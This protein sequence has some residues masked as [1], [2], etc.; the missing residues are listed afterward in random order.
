MLLFLDF[1]LLAGMF[2][3]FPYARRFVPTKC[4]DLVSFI[5]QNLYAG[6]DVIVDVRYWLINNWWKRKEYNVLKLYFKVFVGP[7]YRNQKKYLQFFYKYYFS[8]LY[9]FCSDLVILL[10]ATDISVLPLKKKRGFIFWIITEG[11]RGPTF[12]QN[13]NRLI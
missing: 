8:T 6:S 11:N 1:F 4:V 5:C 7:Y 12:L 3:S 13:F 9:N 10:K 2:H